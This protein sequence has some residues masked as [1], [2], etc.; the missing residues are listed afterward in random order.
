MHSGLYKNH[1]TL[2][3]EEPKEILHFVIYTYSQDFRLWSVCVNV[4]Q[5]SAGNGFALLTLVP[6]GSP[7]NTVVL[8]A[9]LRTRRLCL[10]PIPQKH[11]VQTFK[12]NAPPYIHSLS[13]SS[14]TMYLH[15][16]NLRHNTV[17]FGRCVPALRR[18]TAIV[19]TA[20]CLC[21]YGILSQYLR[22]TAIVFTAYCHSIYG[23]LP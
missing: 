16:C 15:I 10:P 3:L 13:M 9:S 1:A 8:L 7:G 18:Y 2:S 20:Y 6:A 11:T 12:H 17:H 23:I 21:I 22:H 5:T 14:M 4:A 19:F